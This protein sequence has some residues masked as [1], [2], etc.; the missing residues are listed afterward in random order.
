MQNLKLVVAL[1]AVLLSPAALAGEAPKACSSDEYRQFDY[2]IGDWDV[3]NDKGEKV[4]ENLI[5]VEQGGC[6]LHEHWTDAQGGT[7]ESFNMYDAPRGVWHQTWVAANG[8]LLLLEGGLEDGDMVLS[9][10]RPRRDGQGEVHD[11][12]SW[13]AQEDGSVHQVWDQSLDGGKTWQTGFLGIY[14]KK[15]N[16]DQ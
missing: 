13:I 14:R 11:R 2:W 3:F 16:S 8:Q 5:T 9:G 10:K 1:L 6:V 12:I 4:G 7:G 15:V